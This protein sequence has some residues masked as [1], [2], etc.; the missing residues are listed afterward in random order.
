MIRQ[1]TTAREALE[2]TLDERLV[3]LGEAQK[4]EEES[5]E[6][7]I[8]R[9]MKK[10]IDLAA[11]KSFEATKQKE[12]VFSRISELEEQ[13]KQ[14]LEEIKVLKGTAEANDKE[15]LIKNSELE[16]LRGSFTLFVR[17]KDKLDENFKALAEEKKKV[18]HEVLEMRAA[19]QGLSD[20]KDL[21]NR[22]TSK[23]QPQE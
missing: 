21:L 17:E 1:E 20:L 9:R 12:A 2:K 11:S 4:R 19:L 22:Y 3:R 7:K 14:L 8:E 18:D 10:V 23:R 15:I 16:E 6:R 13:N 5:I